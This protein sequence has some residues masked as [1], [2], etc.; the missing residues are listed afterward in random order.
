MVDGN[1]FTG[2]HEQAVSVRDG[3]AKITIRNNTVRGSATAIYNRNAQSIIE[4]NDL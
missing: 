3:A 2:P 1:T 4:R